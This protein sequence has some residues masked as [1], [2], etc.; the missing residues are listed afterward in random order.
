[1]TAPL[2]ARR[3]IAEMRFAF[4]R[5]STR[6]GR[7]NVDW[8][9]VTP[10]IIRLVDRVAYGGRKGRSARRRLDAILGAK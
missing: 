2:Q 1:M 10:L 5:V 3:Y 7:A 8:W 9:R 6:R 4:E